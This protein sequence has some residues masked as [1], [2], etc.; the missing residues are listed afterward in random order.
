MAWRAA[1]Y[2]GIFAILVLWRL[3]PSSYQS[4]LLLPIWLGASLLILLANF[5]YARMRRQVW[6][7]QYMQPDSPWH[8]R[9]RYGHLALGLQLLL[10]IALALVLL[11]KLLI[12]EQALL[13]ALLMGL[14]FMFGLQYWSRKRIRAHVKT[15]YLDTISRRFSINLNTL[16]LGGLLIAVLIGLPQ[17]ALEGL[18][19]SSAML[20]HLEH[21][22]R[23]DLLGLLIRSGELLD[24]SQKWLLQNTIGS[25]QERGLLALLVWLLAFSSYF[26]LSLAYSRLLAGADIIA[27][28]W[29]GASH[30]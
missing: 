17:P 9:L 2:I 10:A 19:W 13:L 3:S 8:A 23:N 16:L 20:L 28:R 22:G 11:I 1:F 12:I 18:P 7:A 29:K 15:P 6:L 30:E 24:L 26:A 5:E 4:W 21:D 14:V 25:V 27:T